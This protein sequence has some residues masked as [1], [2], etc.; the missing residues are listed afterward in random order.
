MFNVSECVNNNC[1]YFFRN[2][3][4]NRNSFCH[5]GQIL[6]YEFVVLVYDLK[7]TKQITLNNS[8]NEKKCSVLHRTCK[9]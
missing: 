7:Q 5:L 9:T 4:T 8:R 3:K 6:M 2:C 1:Y